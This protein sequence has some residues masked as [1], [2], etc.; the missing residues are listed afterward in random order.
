MRSPPSRASQPRRLLDVCLYTGMSS[1]RATMLFARNTSNRACCSGLLCFH[2]RLVARN[3]KALRGLVCMP[4]L[5]GG[6]AVGGRA[7]GVGGCRLAG[8]ELRCATSP[9]FP[10]PLPSSEP[11]GGRD[12]WF[13]P[14][15]HAAMDLILTTMDRV[16]PGPQP[17]AAG[18]AAIHTSRALHPRVL[19]VA[20]SG[21]GHGRRRL[22]D[23]PR[24]GSAMA[25]PRSS[26]R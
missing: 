19:G 18:G 4:A 9:A 8:L 22:C 16:D 5:G 14:S 3:V 6:R 17:Q 10:P 24:T 11:S 12:P 7:G 1:V 2:W 21:P 20:Q 25:A 13:P 23:G 26:R 15:D